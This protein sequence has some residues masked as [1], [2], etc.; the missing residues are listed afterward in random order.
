[1]GWTP[2][3]YDLQSKYMWVTRKENC[4]ICESM[5]G[6]VYT[7]DYFASSGIWPGF[8]DYC[9][10]SLE[11]VSDDTPMSPMDLFPDY[12]VPFL[13]F[14]FYY[15]ENLEPYNRTSLFPP[16]WKSYN[17]FLLDE[18][19]RA[20][21]DGGTISDAIAAFKAGTVHDGSILA[22]PKWKN[23]IET[24]GWYPWISIMSDS[25]LRLKYTVNIF[26]GVKNNIFSGWSLFPGA[27]MVRPVT[28]Y[29][30]FYYPPTYT[31]AKVF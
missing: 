11:K 4:P 23:L 1:M 3:L 17:V 31:G 5:R 14:S 28:P 30:S 21:P 9:D 8:H 25:D 19:M 7:G 12:L 6:R 2:G 20:T 16:G 15:N 18:F 29:Q 24:L 22:Y 26:Q 27:F 13:G 10:C